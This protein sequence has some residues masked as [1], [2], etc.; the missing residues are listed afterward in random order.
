MAI[1]I[2]RKFLVACACWR[3]F[4]DGPGLSFK[5]GYLTEAVSGA[6]VRIRSAGQRGLVTI[7]GPGSLARA[8][9]EYE[10]PHAD[11]EEMLASLCRR[12]LLRKTRYRVEHAGLHWSLDEFHGA[13]DG[14]VLA[15]VELT[16]P[17][18][19]IVLP[20]WTGRE[21]TSDPQYRNSALARGS[22]ALGAERGG[23]AGGGRP[24]AV[25][26]AI[27]PMVG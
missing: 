3:G 26:L 24:P 5:Q 6:T 20:P 22:V 14:L 25:V 8:E 4:A 17:D 7:K 2:E 21:V 9:F 19:P 27:A 10:I 16:A 18:Q 13:L 23:G 15:E 12:P 1:E 11:A